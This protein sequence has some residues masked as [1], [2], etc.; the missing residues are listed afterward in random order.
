MDSHDELSTR[1]VLRTAGSAIR[2]YVYQF[3]QT[4]LA[5]LRHTSDTAVVRVEGVEDLDL[6]DDLEPSAVQIKYL[7]GTRYASPKALRQPILEMLR[8]FA[9]GQE[10]KYVV[11][12][13]FGSGDPPSSLTVEQLREAL[14]KRAVSSGE[15]ELLY[16]QFSDAVIER[17]SKALE[18]RSGE[19]FKEQ[20]A[21]V[22]N[23]LARALGVE[24]DEARD[25][26]YAI[27]VTLI[28]ERAMAPEAADRTVTR[29]SL[30][31]ALKMRTLYYERWHRTI[32][33]REAYLAAV[34]RNLKRSNL[35]RA[36]RDRVL[37]LSFGSADA[38]ATIDL[39]TALANDYA[40]NKRLSSD[41]P[42]TL[43]LRASEDDRLHLKR[44]LLERH[45]WFNDGFEELQF[46]PEAFVALPVVN[47]QGKS[48]L[49]TKTSY[50]LRVASEASF[51]T[52]TDHGG[53]FTDMLSLVEPQ[54]WHR[55]VVT[56]EPQYAS[57]LTIQ[58]LSEVFGRMA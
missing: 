17:F 49:I 2:G 27:A 41:R 51:R 11:H 26:Y 36:R 40:D 8:S 5:V 20:R 22:V 46:A 38:N 39:A 1:Q 19:S 56:S 23:A 4:I 3:D 37:L 47:T 43:V 21:Q 52:I 32:V 7:A 48:P 55:E 35:A 57:G 31:S 28:Q 15:E 58:D 29:G 10:W 33:G 42:W 44:G 25:I 12:V 13:H 16:E 54:D 30:I 6:L 34:V 18:I 14:T 9:E 24:P 45:I 50:K 53:R